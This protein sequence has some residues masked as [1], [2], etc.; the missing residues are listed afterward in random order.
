MHIWEYKNANNPTPRV[1]YVY[2]HVDS[3]QVDTPELC[4]NRLLAQTISVG[5]LD[6][7]DGGWR[8]RDY[9]VRSLRVSPRPRPGSSS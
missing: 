9:L 8:R 4:T 5:A 3:D 1:E 2:Q 6:E 7:K